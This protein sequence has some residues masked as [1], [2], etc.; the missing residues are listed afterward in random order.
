[1]RDEMEIEFH[2]LHAKGK[3]Y[4]NERWCTL[5]T[6]CVEVAPNNFRFDDDKLGSYVF[7]QPENPEEVAACEEAV[8]CCPHEAIFND[9]ISN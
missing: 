6:T 5:C 4:V 2:P 8:A 3:Y 1:M 7:R 9:G